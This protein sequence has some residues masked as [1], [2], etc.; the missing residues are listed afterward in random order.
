VFITALVEHF[1]NFNIFS[2]AVQV[3]FAYL[4]RGILE[5]NEVHV[6]AATSSTTDR[7]M[8]SSCSTNFFQ[9]DS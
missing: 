4:F 5:T 7:R 9:M 8:S 1:G 2:S 6:L 3:Y